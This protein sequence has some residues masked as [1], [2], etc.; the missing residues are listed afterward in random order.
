MPCRYR[1]IDVNMSRQYRRLKNR[2]R[3]VRLLVRW[4]LH[5]PHNTADELKETY[6][7]SL[8]FYTLRSGCLNYTKTLITRNHIS[9]LIESLFIATKSSNISFTNSCTTSQLKSHNSLIH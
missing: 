6:R 8:L 3:L 4:L 2:D 1:A 9:T 5:G 7:I